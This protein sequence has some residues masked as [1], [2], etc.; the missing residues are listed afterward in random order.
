MIS[1]KDFKEKINESFEMKTIN[2]GRRFNDDELYEIKGGDGEDPEDLKFCP[3]LF[4][5]CLIKVNYCI[6]NTSAD[7]GTIGIL[8]ICVCNAKY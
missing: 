5:G 8:G 4:I 7:N 6:S 3:N 1:L 2:K